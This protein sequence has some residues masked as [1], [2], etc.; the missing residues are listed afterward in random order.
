MKTNSENHETWRHNMLSHVDAMI[1]ILKHSE[2]VVTSGAQNPNISHVITHAITCEMFGFCAPDI[3]TDSEFFEI[4][5]IASTCDNI[6]CRQVSRFFEFVFILYI[7]TNDF[8]QPGP[9]VSRG[10]RSIFH[11]AFCI[12][13]GNALTIIKCQD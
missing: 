13:P 1:K 6:L 2:S 3:T 7:K 11:V 12:R 5:I 9:H 4:F 10:K 8:T